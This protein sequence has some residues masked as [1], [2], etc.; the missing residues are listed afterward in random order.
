MGVFD[1]K[2]RATARKK[3]LLFWFSLKLRNSFEIR[4]PR[5]VVKDKR[6]LVFY[7]DRRSLLFFIALGILCPCNDNTTHALPIA[8][9]LIAL[10]CG[11]TPKI[12]HFF[13]VLI[14][15]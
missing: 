5:A 3:S 12:A 7:K 8:K 13:E 11:Y 1:R 15:G 4:K 9:Q 14:K 10:A 2:C 6:I